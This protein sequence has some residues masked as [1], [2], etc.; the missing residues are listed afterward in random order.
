MAPLAIIHVSGSGPV[1]MADIVEYERNNGHIPTGAVV[2][3]RSQA[4]GFSEDAVKFLVHARNVIGIGVQRQETPDSEACSY[5]LSHSAYLLSNVAN[6][7]KVPATGSMVMVAP[8][9]LHGAANGPVRI[10]ALVR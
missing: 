8:S 7:E 5:V 10:L 3:A 2:M 1:A 4:D 9:K 6:L